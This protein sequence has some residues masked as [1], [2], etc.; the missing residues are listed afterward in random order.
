MGFVSGLTSRGQWPR[1]QRPQADLLCDLQDL[2]TRN[3]TVIVNGTLD[4]SR[5]VCQNVLH[6]ALASDYSQKP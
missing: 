3:T 2:Q 4:T 6:R 5:S 1:P